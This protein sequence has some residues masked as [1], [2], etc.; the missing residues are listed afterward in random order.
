MASEAILQ[1][2]NFQKDSSICL[3]RTAQS[4]FFRHHLTVVLKNN[5]KNSSF[6]FIQKMPKNVIY[7]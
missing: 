3:F 6:K 2:E 5:K 4:A 1:F 7:Y